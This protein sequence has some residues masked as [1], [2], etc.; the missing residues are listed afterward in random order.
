MRFLNIAVCGGDES[1]AR[2]CALLC[3][4]GHRV[5]AY[6]LDGAALPEG[7][8]RVGCMEGCLD[9]AE[10]VILPAPAALPGGLL[11]APLCRREISAAELLDRIPE[12]AVICAGD[13]GTLPEGRYIEDYAGREEFAVGCAA[14]TAEGALELAMAAGDSALWGGRA[15]VI[16]YGRLGVILSQRLRGVGAK[17]TAAARR[18]GDTAMAEALGFDAVG[19]DKLD[20][21][22]GEFD[23][24]FNTVSEPAIGVKRLAQIKAGAFMAELAPPPGGFDVKKAEELGIRAVDAPGLAGKYAPQALA[25]LTRDAVYAALGEWL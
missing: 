10:A 1:A 22:L 14:L 15:L 24:I 12:A 9:G 6:A 3:G 16:G 8:M 5:R 25:E 21:R 23:Y 18:G 19:I 11:N 2:L 20:G 7:V 13:A 17:T 4:D